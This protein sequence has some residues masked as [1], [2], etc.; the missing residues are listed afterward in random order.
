MTKS[1]MT[2]GPTLFICLKP[3]ELVDAVKV[4]CKL[5]AK[6]TTLAVLDHSARLYNQALKQELS[7]KQQRYYEWALD[8]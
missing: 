5:K 1:W 2:T 8:S 4:L 7:V 3:F 6:E